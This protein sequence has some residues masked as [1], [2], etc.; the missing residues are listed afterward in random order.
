MKSTR[1]HR[2]ALLMAM[3]AVPMALAACSPSTANSPKPASSLPVVTVG[4]PDKALVQ[5]ALEY[6]GRFEPS[7][8][9]EVRSRLSGYLQ[10][11]TFRD[12]QQVKA[13]DRLF[14]IDTRPFAATRD[15]AAA[16]LNQALARSGLADAQLARN[17]RLQQSGASSAEELDRA[18][19][20]S[21]GAAAAVSL[22]RAEL[23]SAELELS[24]TH[25]DAPI[26]GTIS[27][28]RVDIGNYVGGG[29]GAGGVLTTVVSH[30]PVRVVVELSAAD[31]RRLREHKELPEQ[32]LLNVDGM[33]AAQRAKIDFIDNEISARSGTMRLRASIAN[34]DQIMVPGNFTRVRIPVGARAARLLVPDAVIQNDQS[35]KV[36]MLVDASGKVTP[37]RVELGGLID[38]KRVVLTGLKEDDQLILSG[39][40]RVRPGDRVRIAQAVG[41][42]SGAR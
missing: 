29:G 30:N 42:E 36:V 28:H 21:A 4:T 8:R 24:Y 26:S 22:S 39:A 14:V 37:R 6:T 19:A 27:D 1:P 15:R 23:R 38:G 40:Q 2:P 32:M 18:R 25:I 17:V 20:E 33:P 9:V 10:A 5:D 35:N 7:Q 11:I 13:G 41:G 31:F 16:S 12:G 3:F 34:P